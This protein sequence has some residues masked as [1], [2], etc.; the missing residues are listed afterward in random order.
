M[1]ENV[2]ALAAKEPDAPLLSSKRSEG[3]NTPYEGAE[4]EGD[5]KKL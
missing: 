4:T 1:V 5:N 3:F 2:S